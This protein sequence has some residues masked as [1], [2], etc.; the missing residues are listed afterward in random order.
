MCC[1]QMV[2]TQDVWHGMELTREIISANVAKED[3]ER[4]HGVKK[5]CGKVGG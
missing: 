5:K 4:L 1:V 3:K 2:T